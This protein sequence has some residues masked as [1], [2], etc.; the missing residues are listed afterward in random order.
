MKESA[1][2]PVNVQHIPM[3]RRELL[4]N[5]GRSG[6]A[7]A[8]YGAMTAL[9]LS[10]PEAEGKTTAGRSFALEGEPGRGRRV[11]ILGAGIAGL[12]A[13]YELGKRGYDCRI[14]EARSHPGGRC[15]TIR[16]GTARVETTGAKQVCA[17]DEGHYFNPGPARIPQHHVTLD[18]CRELRVAIEPFAQVNEAAYLYHEGPQF[19][20]LSGKRV[21]TREANAD[22]HGY[23]AELLV[24]ALRQTELDARLTAEDKERLRTFLFIEGGLSGDGVYAGGERR[25]YRTLPG[26]G[27]LTGQGD[28]PHSFS[29][30]LA[31][32]YGYH[33][34][35]DYGLNWQPM[36]F[37]IVG[38]TDRLA[39]AFARRLGEKITY[40]A[41]VTEI[42]QTAGG[43][44]VR[45]LYRDAKGSVR[46]VTG[47]YCICNIPPPVLKG[48]LADFSPAV[49]K[50]V[51]SISYA[52]CGKMGIQFKRRFWE[53]DDRIFGGIT[54]TNLSI[55][56]IFYPSYGYLG[57]KGVLVGYYNFGPDAVAYGNLPHREREA[58]AITEGKRIHPQYPR[59]FENS[60]SVAWEKTPYLTGAW[61]EYD[62]ATYRESYQTLCRPDGRVY[63]AGD[64]VTHQIGWMAGALESARAVVKQIH[65][66]AAQ[67][68]P[69]LRK[70]TRGK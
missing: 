30:L 60:F 4:E 9:G 67:E 44:G 55:T 64:Y 65:E 58:R 47:D 25:G 68:A 35:G 7:S 12:C 16:R 24:K 10:G 32:G 17:F 56:Q 40:S 13:A 41:P 54:K 50:A 38:G 29:A 11:I 21:R 23:A 51:G 49:K 28:A 22:L 43:K 69:L 14:L 19:G 26:A 31:A 52:S 39:Y 70:E 2:C 66:R 18:Y 3:T 15:Q 8:V 36:L 33:F 6:G 1:A 5:I 42:R 20:A 37:Q 62:P 34:A 53:E 63:F 59:E 27:E 46:T 45:V 57:K 61:A 48:I